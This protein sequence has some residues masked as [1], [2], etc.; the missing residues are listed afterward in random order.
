MTDD[1]ERCRHHHLQHLQELA[2]YAISY[3]ICSTR[4]HLFLLCVCRIPL[5]FRVKLQKTFLGINN[6]LLDE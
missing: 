6:L 4:K 5:T 1:L 2:G 3:I